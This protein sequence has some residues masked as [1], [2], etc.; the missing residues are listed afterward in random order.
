QSIRNG[1]RK[2]QAAGALM[3]RQGFC[4]S[5]NGAW[6]LCATVS[7]SALDRPGNTNEATVESRPKNRRKALSSARTELQRMRRAGSRI[8]PEPGRPSETPAS[9]DLDQNKHYGDDQE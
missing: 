2:Y 7:Q 4:A 1:A 8:S 6:N 5:L 3:L 9:D